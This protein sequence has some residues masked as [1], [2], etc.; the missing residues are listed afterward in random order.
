MILLNEDATKVDYSQ[1]QIDAIVSDPPY[2][3]NYDTNHADRF[4]SDRSKEFGREFGARPA[5]N[6]ENIDNEYIDFSFIFNMGVKK[7]ALFGA[8]NFTNQLPDGGSWCVWD[9]RLIK[10][11]KILGSQFELIWFFP[12]RRYDFIRYLFAGMV[13][14][15]LEDT[16]KKVHPTQKPVEVMK[17][18]IIRLKLKDG[19]T[20]LDPFMGSGSTG[21]ACQ[22]LGYK[23]IGVEKNNNYFKVAKKRLWRPLI[24]LC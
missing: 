14:A 18:V 7:I 20:I 4:N 17:E 2:L 23:F 3:I 11:D 15:Q 24:E 16:K 13:G 12:A 8:N 5:K 22:Y 21:V 1:Y 19:A 9:K 6:W 10:A